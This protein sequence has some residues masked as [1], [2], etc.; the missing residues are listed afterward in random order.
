MQA[1]LHVAV[2]RLD[3]PIGDPQSG[4]HLQGARLDGQG[5]RLPGAVEAAVDQPGTCP[6]GG[7]EGGH[8]QA[9]RPGAHD[10]HVGRVAHPFTVFAHVR[11]VC[12]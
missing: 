5:A 6:V 4:E 1:Q 10:Q 2:A 9:G 7:E 12:R 8:R 3:Q 11:V